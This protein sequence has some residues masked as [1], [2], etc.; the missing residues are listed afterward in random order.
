MTGV[1]QIASGKNIF[2]VMFEDGC[3]KYLASNQV[4]IVTVEKIPMEEERQVPTTAVIP[5]ETVSLE[6]IYYHGFHLLI[7]FNK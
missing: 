1:V 3:E 7:N 5:N 2:L 4:T 6:N